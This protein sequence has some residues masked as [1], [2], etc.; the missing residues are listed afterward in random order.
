MQ[1]LA[2]QKLYEI[3]LLFG[4][5]YPLDLVLKQSHLIPLMSAFQS[6]PVL[7]SSEAVLDTFVGTSFN[8]LLEFSGFF[9]T[10]L[11]SLGKGLKRK[12]LS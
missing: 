5:E 6:D 12:L 10:L 8:I 2:L 3:R 9:D 7:E 1:S 11:L 4:R